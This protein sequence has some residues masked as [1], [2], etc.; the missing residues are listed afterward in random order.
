MK[1]TPLQRKTRLT[2]KHSNGK[3]RVPLK[4]VNVE[5]QAKRKAKQQAWYRSP[6]YRRRRKESMER[7]G[8]RCEYIGGSDADV[9][10]DWRTGHYDPTVRRCEETERLQ[11]HEEKYGEKG[12]DPK[13]RKMYCKRHHELVEMRDHP[14]RRHGQ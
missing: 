12:A 2:A 6:E 13:Y 7:A 1:R 9:S 4:K 10:W 8:G 11:M 14:T 5:R 3:P